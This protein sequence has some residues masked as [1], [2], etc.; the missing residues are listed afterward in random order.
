M[1]G[2]GPAGGFCGNPDE[3]STS[4]PWNLA[5]EASKPQRRRR[6][7]LSGAVK[8]MLGH[9][10]DAFSHIRKIRENACG[11]WPDFMGFAGFWPTCTTALNASPAIRGF[12]V[13]TTKIH[14]ALI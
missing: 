3:T 14:S 4:K 9:F 2:S 12:T 8:M 13:S 11:S 10:W 1:G 5:E 6:L 7:G